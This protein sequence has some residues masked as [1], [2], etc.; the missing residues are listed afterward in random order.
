MSHPWDNLILGGVGRPRI[1]VIGENLC[2]NP[3][4]NEQ[5]T[6]GYV[7]T[8]SGTFDTLLHEDG[9]GDYMGRLV[10]SGSGT[11]TIDYEY[12]YGSAVLN[13]M[14]L[15]TVRVQSQYGC[16]IKARSSVELET[17]DIPA[18]NNPEKTRTYYMI[19]EVDT[20]SGNSIFFRIQGTDDINFKFDNLYL[21]E[22]TRDTLFP[23]PQESYLEFKKF[24]D[25]ENTLWNGKHQQFNFKY[26]P[27]YYC[28]FDFHSAAYEFLRQEIS[29]NKIVFCIPH[30]D[31]TWGFRCFWAEDFFRKYSFNK[32]FGHRGTIVLEAEE[33]IY[34]IPYVMG[35]AG[36]L[37]IDGQEVL[38]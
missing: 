1:L 21:T 26:K 37:Y 10:L 19:V 33:Y 5:L 12:D 25:G 15:M 31:T 30:T 36:I 11:T 2:S 27:V 16:T 18:S 32:F 3:Y 28:R 9:I 20:G 29:Q 4:F 17:L 38:V 23:Q 13:K 22:I 24:M 6:T 7:K 34:D 14:F 8:G 35:G